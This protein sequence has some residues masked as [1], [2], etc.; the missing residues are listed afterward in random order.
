MFYLV[1]QTEDGHRLVDYEKGIRPLIPVMS[2]LL[3]EN[4]AATYVIFNDKTLR[5]GFLV[6][7]FGIPAQ[8]DGLL[9]PLDLI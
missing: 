9:V 3:K 8:E 1:A 6:D 5:A 4:P 2:D 7:G